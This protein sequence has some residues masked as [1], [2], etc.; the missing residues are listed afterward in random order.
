MLE[1]YEVQEGKSGAPLD[2]GHEIDVTGRF[3]VAT[4]QGAKKPKPLHATGTQR[5]FLLTQDAQ[6]ALALG[7]TWTLFD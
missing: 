4:C 5:S 1:A 7:K 3:G 6:D 2:L